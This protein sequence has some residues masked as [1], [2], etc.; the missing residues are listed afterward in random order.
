MESLVVLPSK[1][2]IVCGI[3]LI[4]LMPILLS[5][6]GYIDQPVIFFKGTIEEEFN[7]NCKYIH[8]VYFCYIFQNFSVSLYLV[9]STKCKIPDV[10]PFHSEIIK[11]FHP[12]DYIPCRK[13]ELLTYV[14]KT[15]NIATLH[16]NSTMVPLYTTNTMSCCYGNITR[17]EDK[18]RPD[19]MIE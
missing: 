3:S 17:R 14:T 6:N 9:N 13:K 16:I 19:D 10:D 8:V 12:H 4:L 5:K 18:Q 2:A 15:N 7:L 11:F 1:I